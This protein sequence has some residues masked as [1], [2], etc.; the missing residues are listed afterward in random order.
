VYLDPSSRTGMLTARG[1]PPVE[2]GHAWQLWFVRGN[3]R[4]SGGV[5]WPDRSGNCYSMISVPADVGSFETMGMTEEPGQGSAW[6]TSQRVLW[7]KI[8]DQ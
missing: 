6:P 8:S 5:V 4:V 1:L 3:E 2:P 7:G